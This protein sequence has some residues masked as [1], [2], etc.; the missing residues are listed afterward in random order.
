MK[1]NEY[2]INKQRME[3]NRLSTERA[4]LETA[5]ADTWMKVIEAKAN[6]N[7]K[8]PMATPITT[9]TSITTAA[10]TYILYFF[11]SYQFF[12]DNFSFPIT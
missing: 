8:M 7:A 4:R 6:N 12:F 5:V 11:R 2:I 1:E 9:T 10:T 3:I